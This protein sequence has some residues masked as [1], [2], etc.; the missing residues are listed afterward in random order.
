MPLSAYYK[1]RY[2]AECTKAFAAIV[3]FVDVAVLWLVFVIACCRSFRAVAD[4]CGCV[5]VAASVAE[6]VHWR[7]SRQSIGGRAVMSVVEPHNV[8]VSVR[9]MYASGR[10]TSRPSAD[11]A[12]S[13][14][15]GKMPPIGAWSVTSISG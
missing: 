13:L 14:S 1:A 7:A 15:V 2:R 10:A 3:I 9:G 8:R 11:E 4:L 5:L 6:R 12:S